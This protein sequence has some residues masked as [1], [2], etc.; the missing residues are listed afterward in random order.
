VSEHRGTIRLGLVLALLVG[1]N[2]Y[3]FWFRGGTSIPEVQKA[4]MAADSPASNELLE[5][6]AG[7]AELIPPNPFLPLPE[8]DEDPNEQGSWIEGAIEKGDS[9]GR[10]MKNH[11]FDAQQTDELVRALRPHMEFRSIRVGQTYRIHTRDDGSLEAFE[12]DLSRVHKV[13]VER[14]A[15]GELVGKKL[16]ADTQIRRHRV[17]GTVTSSLYHAVKDAGE[18]TALVGFLVDVFAYDLNF[19]I[20]QHKGDTFRIVVEK[21]FLGDEFLRYRKVRAAEYS[22]KAG[23]FR[24]FYWESKD[25]KV[26]GYYNEKGQAIARTFLKTPLKYSRISSKFNPNRMHPVLHKRR[27]HMGVDYAA[28]TGTPVWAA[29]TGKI[30][31]RGWGGGAGNRVVIDHGNG[32]KTVYMHLSRFRKGQKVGSTVKQ[33]TVIGYVG[34]TGLATGAH[35]HFSV[36]KH[37]KYIDPMKMKMARGPGVPRKYRAAFEAEISGLVAQ[38]GDV[39]TGGVTAAANE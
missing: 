3:V 15:A 10:V 14:N 6:A 21:E 31:A 24:A 32:Y 39:P 22:G 27:A 30:V 9:I 34:A 19:Y 17:G 37:G 29:A 20:D 33:K 8:G 1:V 23:T 11:G 12:Y 36:K 28:A 25:G 35:L 4:A 7:A 2:L 18:D 38:L 13:V 5:P 26:K 16:E